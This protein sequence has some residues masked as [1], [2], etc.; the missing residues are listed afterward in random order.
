[1]R[2]FGKRRDNLFTAFHAAIIALV[3]CGIFLQG[4]GYK[5][6]PVYLGCTIDTPSKI[7]K[8]DKVEKI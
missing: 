1:M 3:F 7:I 4:C 5:T 6:K 2:L 8:K